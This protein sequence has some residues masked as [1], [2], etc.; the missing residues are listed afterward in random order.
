VAF[1]SLWVPCKIRI[2]AQNQGP[3]QDLT[4][5]RPERSAL[6]VH[7]VD[8]SRIKFLSATQNLDEKAIFQGSLM[9]RD[10]VYV[11]LSK[12]LILVLSIQLKFENQILLN[13]VS[14]T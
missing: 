8:M 2:F 3:N 7:I 11:S 13:L 5:R 4:P 10:G 1:I 12:H 9:N 14:T 6:G